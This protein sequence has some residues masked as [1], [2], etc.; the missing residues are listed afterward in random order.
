MAERDNGYTESRESKADYCFEFHV[1]GASKKIPFSR[2]VQE[3]SFYAICQS[4]NS[5]ELEVAIGASLVLGRLRDERALPFLLEAFLSTNGKKAQAVAWALGELADARAVPFL[6]EALAAK[7]IPKSS[8]IALGKIGASSSLDVLINCL[9]D[10]DETLRA[11]AV[12]SIGQLRYGTQMELKA[13]AVSVLME[14]LRREV[15]R[16]VRLAI[17]VT[18][19]RLEKF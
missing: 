1:D 17:C 18:C 12:K 14:Q 10:R 2:L 11:L 6:T 7:F 13:R 4:L 5:K 15:S 19:A 9:K 3:D 8:I 16:A